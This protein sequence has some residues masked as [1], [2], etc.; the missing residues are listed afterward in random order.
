MCPAEVRAPVDSRARL[1][2]RPGPSCLPSG[3]P[4]HHSAQ[5]TRTHLTLTQNRSIICFLKWHFLE[6]TKNCDFILHTRSILEE[7]WHEPISTYFLTIFCSKKGKIRW[8]RNRNNFGG[9]DDDFRDYCTAALADIDNLSPP[10]L[11]WWRVHTHSSC[12][13]CLAKHRNALHFT[14]H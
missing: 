2:R 14:P 7:K 12:L 8:A 11:I 9:V 1:Q 3:P 13:D 5:H 6:K 10:G 4:N